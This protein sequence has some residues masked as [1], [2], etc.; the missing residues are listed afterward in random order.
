MDATETRLFF[1][2]TPGVP[3][4]YP[5]RTLGAP[6][7]ARRVCVG[8]AGDPMGLRGVGAAARGGARTHAKQLWYQP[9]C[10]PCTQGAQDVQD[11]LPVLPVLPV[12]PVAVP[13][14]G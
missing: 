14:A 5:W 9:Q 7:A 12:Q 1:G 4:A 2:P 6:L 13:A 8:Y 3:L 11:V 10:T